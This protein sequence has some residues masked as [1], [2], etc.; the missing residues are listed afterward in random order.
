MSL[1]Q[2]MQDARK[3]AEQAELAFVLK[4]GEPAYCGFAWVD[5]LVD[6]TNSKQAKELIRLGF[7]KSYR[8]RCLTLWNPGG[9]PTQSM[10]VKETGAQAFAKV[11]QQA[12]VNAYMGSRAD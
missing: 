9:S 10:D 5:V 7:K 12:G 2:V 3:A 11:L 8:P 6:R 4:H 1:D